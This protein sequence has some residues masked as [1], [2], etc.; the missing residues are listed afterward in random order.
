M[1]TDNSL[2]S[3][4]NRATEEV[5]NVVAAKVNKAVENSINAFEKKVG[6]L[7]HRMDEHLESRI[8]KEEKVMEEVSSLRK[9]LGSNIDG[10]AREINTKLELNE[11]RVEKLLE[12]LRGEVKKERFLIREWLD[13]TSGDFG[14]LQVKTQ[15]L[16]DN[17]A[18]TEQNLVKKQG[19]LQTITHGIREDVDS[20]G[21]LTKEHEE[22]LGM[23]K[24][25]TEQLEG[26]LEALPKFEKS[27][28]DIRRDFLKMSTEQR[29]TKLVIILTAVVLFVLAVCGIIF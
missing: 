28:T 10:M 1:T 2:L 15:A 25:V 19:L 17:V 13:S 3:M 23:L 5:D 16:V 9:E 11:N 22:S 21:L 12:I 26:A 8:K 18:I 14:K 20:M 24:P 7:S 6:E 27:L 4:L 29:F